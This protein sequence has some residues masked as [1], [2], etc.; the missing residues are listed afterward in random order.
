MAKK[1]KKTLNLN[2]VLALVVGVLIG[3]LGTITILK[4]QAAAN[5][6]KGSSYKGGHGGG[7]CIDRETGAIVK[8]I[9]N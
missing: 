2:I 7:V 8:V 3:C 6:P 1:I 9:N 5:C 4:S